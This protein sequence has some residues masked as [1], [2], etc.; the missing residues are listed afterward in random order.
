VI[1][2]VEQAARL[3]ALGLDRQVFAT[4]VQPG[5]GDPHRPAHVRGQVRDRQTALAADLGL[6]R[7]GEQDW[8]HEHDLAVADRRA[9]VPG[10]VHHD[11]AHHLAELCR[12]H[13]GGERHRPHRVDQ[14]AGHPLRLLGVGGERQLSPH[15]L[16]RRMWVAEDLAD[17]H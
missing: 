3:E 15:R 10:H 17:A 13:A 16:E 14:V 9:L 2:L 1:D 7:R 12:R 5:H 4:G 6:L 11:H 8:V